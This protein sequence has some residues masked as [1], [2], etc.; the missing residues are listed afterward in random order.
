[1]KRHSLTPPGYGGDARTG[2]VIFKLAAELKPE[3]GPE[4]F[5][6]VCAGN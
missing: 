1:M 3:V 2:A 6:V 5:I 4:I